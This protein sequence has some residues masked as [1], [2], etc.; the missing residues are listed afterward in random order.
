MCCRWVRSFCAT[1]GNRRVI[2]VTNA[3]K[4]GIATTTTEDIS[5][6]ICETEIQKRLSNVGDHETF[7]AMTSTEPLITVW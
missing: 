2:P 3:M 1:T 7:E 6:L 4:D 5:M